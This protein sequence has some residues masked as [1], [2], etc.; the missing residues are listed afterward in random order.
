MVME[1]DVQNLEKPITK[2]EFFVVLKG[3][4]KD[5]SPSLDRWTVEFFIHYFDLV[6]KDLM[7]VVE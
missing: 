7:E 1:E 3:F 6:A 4:T 5:K 2:E